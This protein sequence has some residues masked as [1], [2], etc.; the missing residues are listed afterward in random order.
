MVGVLGILTDA[1]NRHIFQPTY[2][3][4][5]YSRLKELLY[6]LS[7]SEPEKERFLR[8]MLLSILPE[9]QRPTEEH[10]VNNTLEELLTRSGIE[11]IIPQESTAQFRHSLKQIIANAQTT[12]RAAQR[13]MHIFECEFDYE[14]SP[15]ANWQMFRFHG[16]DDKDGANIPVD[17]SSDEPS[18]DI[19][20]IVPQMTFTV[21]D[22]DPEPITTGVVVR[23]SEIR[24]M[25]RKERENTQPVEQTPPRS[26]RSTRER[27]G[28]ESFLT[29]TAGGSRF[30][31]R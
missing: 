21:Q 29:R 31:N 8:G 5:E 10:A 16:E 17:V 23:K 25:L 3:L 14:S 20:V 19:V 4:P 11:T 7:S 18:G 22:E 12:W 27:R 2:V 26:R 15:G 24:T 1:I 13:S 9:E 28:S 6:M 30:M